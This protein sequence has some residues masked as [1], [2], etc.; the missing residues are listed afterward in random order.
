MKEASKRLASADA[1]SAEGR[2]RAHGS[3]PGPGRRGRRRGADA[4]RRR[5]WKCW[6]GRGR[7]PQAAEALRRVAAALL[8]LGAAGPAR[9][10]RGLRTAKPRTRAI[11][12]QCPGG[13]AQRVRAV[14]ARVRPP[15]SAGAGGAAGDRAA[16]AGG[17][18]AGPQRQEATAA[19][20]GGAGPAGGGAACKRK[21]P[22]LCRPRRRPCPNHETR[23]V[24]VRRAQV[25]ARCTSC[26]KEETIM[27]GRYPAGL[28]LIDKLDGSA[29]S[30]QRLKT[31]LSTMLAGSG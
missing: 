2:D 21:Q 16:A 6:P 11:G 4:W 26:S 22:L 29:Q 1:S 3:G 10:A 8:S 24:L 23:T 20:A 12:G 7:R 18:E 30:K 9:Y 15:A 27:R 14:A 13:P 31:I 28:E 5:S 17:G 25:R 19:P